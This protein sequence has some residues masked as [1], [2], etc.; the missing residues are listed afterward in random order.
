MSK[1][2]AM[3]IKGALARIVNQLDLSTDEMRDV[4]REIM[5]GKCTDA[6]IGAF[7]MAMRMKSESIDEI[8]GAVSVMRE[9]ADKVELKTLD[10][11]VD[12]LALA[13]MAPIF[14]TFRRLRRLSS[15][16]RGA[17]LPSTVTARY[18]VKVA[19]LICWRPQAFI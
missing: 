14:L 7:M 15:R 5:T 9:L 6:Q 11:V 2:M 10:G 12:V 4:M 19:V 3:D 18:P 8:V 13:A 16:R 1:V 17:R